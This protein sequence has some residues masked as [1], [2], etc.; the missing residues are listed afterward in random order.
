MAKAEDA[1]AS[2][3]DENMH[4][5]DLHDKDIYFLDNRIQVDSKLEDEK[6]GTVKD[7]D[8]LLAGAVEDGACSLFR[9]FEKVAEAG[10]GCL[11]PVH[12]WL[13]NRLG[14]GKKENVRQ[15]E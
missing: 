8:F 13:E 4:Q 12:D 11:H 7:N 14:V 5:D 15:T 3:D 9:E 1:D 6:T 10:G 2:I